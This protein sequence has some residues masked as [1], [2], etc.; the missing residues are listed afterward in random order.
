[1]TTY[2]T[3]EATLSLERGTLLKIEREKE[4]FLQRRASYPKPTC[5]EADGEKKGYFDNDMHHTRS[6]LRRCGTFWRASH[7]K[8]FLSNTNN[9]RCGCCVTPASTT[10]CY[11]GRI[12]VPLL[13]R[14]HH[15]QNRFD[16]L[17]HIPPAVAFV[18]SN[19][20]FHAVQFPRSVRN[21]DLAW[22]IRPITN[23]RLVIGKFGRHHDTIGDET[24][25]FVV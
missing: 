21:Y 14:T 24:E 3:P 5:L 9:L 17:K 15:L 19:Y 11:Y 16:A 1:M 10:H 8:L 4:H 20:L 23:C 13:T 7:R 18:I 25:L 2:I 12:D 6:P 22:K